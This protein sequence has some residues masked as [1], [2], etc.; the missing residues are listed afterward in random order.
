MK[1]S[2]H[3]YKII[4][5]LCK[6]IKERRLLQFYFESDTKG[7][8]WRTIRPYMVLPRY[9]KENLDFENA[10]ELVGLPTE[11][12]KSAK[13][14]PGHYYLHKLDMSRFDV[15]NETFDEP[16]VSRTIVTHTQTPVVCRFIYE[17]EDVKEVTKTWI[18]ILKK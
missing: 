7:K 11:Q 12:L 2:P 10:L 4:K 1:V 3:I 16:G 9:T 5:L 6:A 13:K 15:F 17:D 18:K 14:Q 8:T